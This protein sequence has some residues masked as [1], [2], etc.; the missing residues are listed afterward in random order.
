M[1]ASTFDVLIKGLLQYLRA[2]FPRRRFLLGGM[3][4]ILYRPV[5]CAC[6]HLAG[7]HLRKLPRLS[8]L[9]TKNPRSRSLCARMS[10]VLAQLRLT[11]RLSR[12]AQKQTTRVRK[13]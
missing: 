4:T 7:A 10:T 12:A 11:L 2:I 9:S 3:T 6:M 8:H 1:L 13:G 5:T